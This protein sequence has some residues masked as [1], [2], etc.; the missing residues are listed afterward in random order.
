MVLEDR[1]GEVRPSSPIKPQGCD[2][3][4]GQP[5]QLL[6]AGV[7]LPTTRASEAIEAE[8]AGIEPT[9]RVAP[10]PLVLKTRGATRPRSPPGRVWH[11]VRE[12]LL[13]G[14]VGASP[15]QADERA[16]HKAADVRLRVPMSPGMRSINVAMA[17]AMV[18]GE[19]LRQTGG[20]K[21]D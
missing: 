20:F 1:H 9:G 15:P 5:T 17:A 6:K 3:Y 13:A 18:A 7:L 10:V 21:V 16:E 14:A 8:V 19:A 4:D 2:N 11:G 12:L